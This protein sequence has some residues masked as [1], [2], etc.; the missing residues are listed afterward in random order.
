LKKG[1]N[2]KFRERRT[3]ERGSS[4]KEEVAQAF[5][6][7]LVC[8]EIFEERK[9]KFCLFLHLSI[10]VGCESLLGK[11]IGAGDGGWV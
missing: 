5:E 7:D 2:D 8:I 9:A 1:K 3:G 11:R 4:R 10:V 6:E